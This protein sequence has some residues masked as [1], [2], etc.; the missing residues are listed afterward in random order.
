M[1]AV[2]ERKFSA[3]RI[4]ICTGT[5]PAIPPIPG[6]D[7]V[8]LLTNEN[9]FDLTEIPTSMTIIG[10]GAIGCEM[11]QAFSQLGCK[12]TIVQMD[13]H[14]VPI[15]DEDMGRV[16]EE[17]F[18]EKGIAVYNSR[19]IT[20]IEKRDSGI[21]LFTEQGEKIVSEKLLVAAGRRIRWM[22]SNCKMPV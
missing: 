19:S 16:L 7:T 22:T 4:Y 13:A 2:G 21:A 9:M 10:G 18:K 17:V 20:R 5:K 8:D 15:G 1:V 12:C 14:L 3:Q 11:A 6:I